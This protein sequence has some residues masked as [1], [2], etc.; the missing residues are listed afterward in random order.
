MATSL[1][2]MAMDA[3]DVAMN[4]DSTSSEGEFDGRREVA[5]ANAFDFPGRWM[6]SNFH[7]PECCL[8]QKRRGFVT[9]SRGFEL[10]RDM[11]DL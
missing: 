9:D 11:R 8:R 10:R 5:S 7:R 6:M 4:A 3:D 2:E 1:A